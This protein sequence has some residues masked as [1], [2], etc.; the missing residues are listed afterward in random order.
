VARAVERSGN[1]AEVCKGGAAFN[2]V[3]KEAILAWRAQLAADK[4]ATGS[5]EIVSSWI[6][7]GIGPILDPDCEMWFA[8]QRSNARPLHAAHTRRF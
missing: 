3:Y 6:K 1:A 4:K 7:C 5:N 2:K 8:H